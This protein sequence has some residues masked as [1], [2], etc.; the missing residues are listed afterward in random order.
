MQFTT[1]FLGAL[2][3]ASSAVAAPANL[4]AKLMTAVASQWTITDFTRTCNQADTSCHISFG[5][6]RN[7]GSAVQ[8]CA[9]DVTGQPASRTDYNSVAC[10]PYTISSGW[11]GQFGPDAGFTTL[12]VTDKKQIIYPAYTDK[13]LASGQAV[14]PDQSY[15][16]QALP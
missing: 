10:G 12:A 11:S 14:K 8:K 6:N 9:Y 15:A 5:I 7:D 3:A 13:Q 2:A 16:P 1:L 4:E